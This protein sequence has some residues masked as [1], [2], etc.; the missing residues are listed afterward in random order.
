MQANVYLVWKCLY[1]FWNSRIMRGA[2]LYFGNFRKPNT[3]MYVLF[4]RVVKLSKIISR[5]NFHEEGY[6]KKFNILSKSKANNAKLTMYWKRCEVG[7]FFGID[8]FL[9]KLSHVEQ[10]VSR[11]LFKSPPAKN[12]NR[13]AG[14][15]ILRDCSID[16][17]S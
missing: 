1:I 17:A 8:I 11:L 9:S 12:I 6:K 2:D 3:Q 4:P 16:G 7:K 15:G 13:Y 10:Y 5:N 14:N